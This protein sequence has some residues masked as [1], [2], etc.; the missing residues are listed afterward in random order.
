MSS[1]SWELGIFFEGFFKDSVKLQKPF[2]SEL[3]VSL[4][5]WGIHA[6]VLSN[7]SRSDR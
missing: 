3:D 7:F 5:M 2:D 4:L 1:V 6:I